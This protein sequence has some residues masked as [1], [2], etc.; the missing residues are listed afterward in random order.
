MFTKC[1]KRN[2]KKTRQDIFDCIVE[3]YSANF[4]KFVFTIHYKVKEEHGPPKSIKKVRF[5][6]AGEA[7]AEA[8]FKISEKLKASHD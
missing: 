3:L 5:A 4:G 6:A 1:K 2:N 7:K 8:I